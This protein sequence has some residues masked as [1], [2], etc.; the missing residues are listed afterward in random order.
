MDAARAMSTPRVDFADRRP[1]RHDDQLPGVQAVGQLVELGEP[2]GHADHLAAAV[3]DGLDLVEGV[4]HDVAERCVVLARAPVGDVVDLRLGSVDHLVDVAG[5]GV[6]HGH[7]AGAGLDEPAQDGLLPHDAPVVPGVGRRG[8]H[9]DEG[10][11]VGGAAHPAELPRASQVGRDGDGV[12]RLPAPVEV[13][14]R[15]VHDRVGGPVEVGL[16][17]HLDDVGDG[18]LAQQHGADDGLLG[19]DVVRRGAIGAGGLARMQFRDAH[20]SPFCA[21]SPGQ[22]ATAPPRQPPRYGAGLTVSTRPVDRPVDDMGGAP[23]H[24]AGPLGTGWGFRGQSR[25]LLPRTTGGNPVPSLWTKTR[26]RHGT[27]LRP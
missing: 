9:R 11:Q 17:Q 16:P 15:G 20:R 22:P 25:A 21:I 18:V 7:D 14:D 26:R 6:A 1:G 23:P 4:A 8:D 5:A 10:V 19:G 27:S 24:P 13:E 2:G 12:G 3:G